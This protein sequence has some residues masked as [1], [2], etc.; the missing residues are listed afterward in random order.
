MCARSRAVTVGGSSRSITSTPTPERRRT[1][2]GDLGYKCKHSHHLKTDHGWTDGPL[3]PN[4]KRQL[5][6]PNN[7][8]TRH[9]LRAMTMCTIRPATEG[10]VDA[11]LEFWRVA[12]AEPSSTD[13]AASVRALIAHDP[14]A[15]LVAVDGEGNGD[16]EARGGGGEGGAEG[17]D[18]VTEAA[19]GSSDR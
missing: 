13:D 14:G 9:E 12:T 19:G 11:V 17:G 3:Q 6:P 16:G 4:G 10:E 1:D 2:I 5:I 8:T 7:T 18:R 15:L